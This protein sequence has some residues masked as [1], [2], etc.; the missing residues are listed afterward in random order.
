MEQETELNFKFSDLS[1]E[2]SGHSTDYLTNA[3]IDICQVLSVSKLITARRAV[4]GDKMIYRGSLTVRHHG[5]L[6][7]FICANQ[8]ADFA[9]TVAGSR[10]TQ[11]S[12][13]LID[14]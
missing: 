13:G 11:E 2:R 8:G 7:N 5:L 6:I 4:I 14:R 1:S 12:G 10:W 3:Q 9:L